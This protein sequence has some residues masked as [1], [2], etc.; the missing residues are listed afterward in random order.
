VSAPVTVTLLPVSDGV[1]LPEFA[2]RLAQ[3]LD[4][5]G[6][7]RVVDAA[8]VERG[9]NDPACHCAEGAGIR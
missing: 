5:F 7:V 3:Q 9:L 1:A 8:A 2:R 6:R 4:R